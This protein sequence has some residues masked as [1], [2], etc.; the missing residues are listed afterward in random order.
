MS[1]SPSTGGPASR[2][3]RKPTRAQL[4]AMEAR[5][6]AVGREAPSAKLAADGVPVTR[7]V[8]PVTSNARLRQ[9]GR[10]ITLTREQEYDYIT[11]DLRRLVIIASILL[12]LMLVILYI[13]ER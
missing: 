7:K 4:R 12:V 11:G 3:P 5:N 2:P 10:T 1:S 6:A 9:G 8:A 13:V